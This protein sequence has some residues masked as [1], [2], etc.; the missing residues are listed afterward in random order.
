MARRRKAGSERTME[1][2]EGYD[3]AGNC[4]YLDQEYGSGLSG[5]FVVLKTDPE[6]AK[7]ELLPMLNPIAVACESEPESIESMLACHH[8]VLTAT[9]VE[10][11]NQDGHIAGL[12]AGCGDGDVSHTL[13]EAT[14]DAGQSGAWPPLVL[15]AWIEDIPSVFSDHHYLG[16]SQTEPTPEAESGEEGASPSSGILRVLPG[17]VSGFVRPVGH[18]LHP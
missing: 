8:S 11:L 9:D 18:G 6:N 2:P 13:P 7:E 1:A 4:L 3:L 17:E 10:G 14:G 5:D 16:Q 12:R 15:H